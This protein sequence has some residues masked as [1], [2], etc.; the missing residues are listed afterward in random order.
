MIAAAVRKVSAHKTTVRVACRDFQTK[1]G[2]VSLGWSRDFLKAARA[3]SNSN[4]ALLSRA[5]SARSSSANAVKLGKLPRRFRGEVSLGEA[6]PIE[7]KADLKPARLGIRRAARVGTHGAES[8]RGLP[9]YFGGR[10]PHVRDGGCAHFALRR[11]RLKRKGV[12][13][14][15]KRLF[16][17]G[18]LLQFCGCSLGT[19]HRSPLELGTRRPAPGAVPDRRLFSPFSCPAAIRSQS[20]R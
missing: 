11:I 12:I 16:E 10:F 1:A 2:S 13:Q 7:L 8:D 19:E 17:S 15:S 18:S 5:S 20:L 6:A 3:R 14:G 4:N 9:Q